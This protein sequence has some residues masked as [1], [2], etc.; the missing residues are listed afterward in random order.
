MERNSKKDT[1]KI[2]KTNICSF[3]C[4]YVWL[5]SSSHTLPL[6]NESQVVWGQK[7]LSS[8]FFENLKVG[9]IVTFISPSLPNY[10]LPA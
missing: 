5:C 7:S 9:H 4:I 3:C 1:V 6:V 2:L 8:H 10:L